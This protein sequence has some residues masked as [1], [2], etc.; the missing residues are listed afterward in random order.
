MNKF[1][2]NILIAFVAL[3]TQRVSAAP[4][5]FPDELAGT[6]IFKDLI[7]VTGSF[8]GMTPWTKKKFDALKPKVIGKKMTINSQSVTIFDKPACKP[9]SGLT[10]TVNNTDTLFHTVEEAARTPHKADRLFE[11]YEK[12]LAVVIKKCGPKDG[13]IPTKMEASKLKEYIFYCG[14]GENDEAFEEYGNYLPNDS[15]MY[16]IDSETILVSEDQFYTCLK[17]SN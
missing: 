6:W 5:P 3:A 7:T 12:E 13:R 15:Q 14:K 1:S 2:T 17:K 11:T 16:M 8:Q 10:W 9:G 4:T